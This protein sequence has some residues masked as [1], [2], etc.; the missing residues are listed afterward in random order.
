MLSFALHGGTG[1]VY[2]N[3][4]TLGADQILPSGGGGIRFLLLKDRGANI[5]FDF[6]IG[7]DGNSG[8]YFCFGESF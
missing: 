2:G 7:K 1:R 3:R 8:V 4:T 6:A 5:G